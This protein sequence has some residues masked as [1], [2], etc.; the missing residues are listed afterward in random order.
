MKKS[1]RWGVGLVIAFLA[2]AAGVVV[3]VVVSMNR[4]VDLVADDYYQQELRHEQQIQSTRR[5]D[6]LGDSLHVHLVG[7]S[8][9][10]TL[11]S[12]FNPDSTQGTLT[13][14]RPA[15]RKMDFV[16]PLLLTQGNSQA[17]DVGTLERG[18]WRIKVRWTF[19]QTEYF[20]EE[21]IIIQ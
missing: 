12:V 19:R 20:K 8:L 9:L 5:T 13:F 21:A 11:P 14:Y 4:E 18:L 6:A 1:N 2:F 16:V 17:V 10:C 15:D 7:T 3:M